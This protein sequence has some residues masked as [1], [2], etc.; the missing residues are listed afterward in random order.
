MPQLSGFDVAR[1]I[2][3][4]R[5]RT[6]V[7]YMSG[8]TDNRVSANWVFEPS[9]PFLPKPFTVK[10]LAEK[11]RETLDSEASGTAGQRP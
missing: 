6:R 10:A 11:V 2:V 4:M 7:L 1:E 3:A 5:P 9:T 8:Y